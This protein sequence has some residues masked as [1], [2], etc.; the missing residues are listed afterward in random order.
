MYQIGP[1]WRDLMGSIAQWQLWAYLGLQDIKLR[2]RR[3]ILGPFWITLSMAMTIIGGGYSLCEDHEHEHARL[4]SLFYGWL[5]R[6]DLIASLI[7]DGSTGLYQR[8]RHIYGKCPGR[9]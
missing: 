5:S 4:F 2:Y 9:C 6:L 8:W 7:T 3:S 1:A